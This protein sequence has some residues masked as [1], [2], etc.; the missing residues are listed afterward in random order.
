MTQEK[1]NWQPYNVKAI[2]KNVEQVFKKSDI[3]Y[4]KEATYKFIINDMG[5]IAHYDLGGFQSEYADLRE[6]VVKLQTSEYSTQKESNLQ[7][8]DRIESDP[9]FE[10]W[11]GK[12]YNKSKAEA[13]RGIVAVARKYEKEIFEKFN[14]IE[15]E[16]EI[17]QAR[18]LAEK[19]GYILERIK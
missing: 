8:A 12:L 6:F 11:Y 9:D 10:K 16:Q 13:I 18:I 1:G 14:A 19:H 3:R 17:N 5:F 4:L 7:E 2:V 15:K